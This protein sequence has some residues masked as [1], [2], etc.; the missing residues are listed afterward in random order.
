[1]NFGA[2]ILKALQDFKVC[3]IINSNLLPRPLKIDESFQLK[4]LSETFYIKL[5]NQNI[6]PCTIP[7]ICSSQ[8]MNE[9]LC[10]ALLCICIATYTV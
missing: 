9:I 6:L 8:T 7:P 5:F 1:M 2:Y 4:S 10:T 3:R